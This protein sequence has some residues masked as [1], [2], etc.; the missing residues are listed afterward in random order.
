MEESRER[1]EYTL[2]ARKPCFGLPTA[3]PICLPVYIYLKLARFP[4]RLDFNSTYPDSDQ[5][6]YVESGVY[7][8]YN[9]ENG[10]VIQR[11]KEDGIVN[12]DAEFCSIPEWISLKAMINSWLL[13]AIT[14][15]LWLGSAGSSAFKSYYSDLPWLI[16][17]ALFVK[18]TYTVKQRLGITKENAE[19]REVEIYKRAKIAYAALSTR[20]GEQEF[21]FDDRASSLDAFFLGHVLYTIQALPETSVLRSSLLEHGNLVRYAEKFK[22]NFLESDS[23]SS[24]IPRFHPESSSSTPRRGPSN[25]SSKP[26]RKP[27]REKTEEEKTFKRRGKY[28]L[29]AQAVAILLF[30]SL[31]SGYDFSEVDVD[32]GDGGYGYD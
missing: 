32:G 5:I 14:Y 15:E 19:R 11:L 10:G 23:S 7:V 20:L 17:K 12:L 4:F 8:A 24:S 22:T 28:F 25:Y 26:N 16:G 21:L 30:L 1:E 18:Q 3:C 9:N 31:M 2:V 29:L 27:K 6:P 13:D